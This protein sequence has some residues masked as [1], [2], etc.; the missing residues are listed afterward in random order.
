MSKKT[1]KKQLLEMARIV[2]AM[3][4]ALS[5]YIAAVHGIEYLLAW[6]GLAAVLLLTIWAGLKLHDQQKRD[7]H[8]QKVMLIKNIRAM[9]PFDFEQRVAGVYARLGYRVTNT[10]DRGDNGIDVLLRKDGQTIAVQVKRYAG[11]NTIGEP[12]LREFYGSYAG[13]YHKGIYV[14]TSS[15]TRQARA[16]AK[17]R[18]I[19]LVDW[20]G[21]TD[22]ER[23]VGL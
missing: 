6:T 20:D 3:L 10:P 4:L 17:P 23:E 13:Q 18:N 8:L 7:R 14:T 22:L 2:S 15:Y 9:N 12:M 5:V 1:R 21:W 11:H 16:W 19:G